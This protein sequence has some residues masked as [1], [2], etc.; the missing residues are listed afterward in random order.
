MIGGG[1]RLGDLGLDAYYSSL[2]YGGGFSAPMNGGLIFSF[3]FSL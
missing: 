1:C 3:N 2:N